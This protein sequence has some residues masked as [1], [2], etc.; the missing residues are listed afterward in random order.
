MSPPSQQPR[1]LRV[2]VLQGGRITD[3]RHLRRPETVTIGKDPRA[4]LVLPGDAVPVVFPLFEVDGASYRLVFTPGME[5][6]VQLSADED[7]TLA[8]LAGRATPHAKGLSIPLTEQARGNVTFDGVTVF[9]QFVQA[10]EVAGPVVFDRKLRGNIFNGMDRLFLAMLAGSL[11]IHFTCGTGII[12]APMPVEPEL[13]LDELP[14]RFVQALIQREPPK[15]P[16]APTEQTAPGT[17]ERKEEPTQVAQQAESQPAGTPNAERREQ[18]RARVANMGLVGAL[19]SGGGSVADVLGGGEGLNAD[20]ASAL[21]GVTGVGVATAE[22]VRTERRG[23]TAGDVAGIG[24]VATSGAGS[25]DLAGKRDVEVTGRV[26]SSAPEVDSADVNPADIARYVRARLT[27]IQNCYERELKRNQSL[28]GRVVVAFTIQ[29]NGRTSDVVIDENTLGNEAV[30]TCI[31]SLIRTW[32][33]PFRP[34]AEVP[35]SYP[36]VFS[37]AS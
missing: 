11:L 8:E 20:F 16:P 2:G 34:E 28:R 17:A 31:R 12:L 7:L 5:G 9:F 10:P 36:F 14:D 1:V 19:K 21:S 26:T 22:A 23:G 27:A 29:E 35:V 25:V 30:G 15:P 37:P 4:S 6:R 3:E 18:A 32:A 24:D 33:F 13:A